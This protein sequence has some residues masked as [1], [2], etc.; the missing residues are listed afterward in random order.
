M[1]EICRDHSANVKRR[2]DEQIALPFV[3]AGMVEAENQFR[4]MNGFL[5]LRAPSPESWRSLR[6]FR[7]NILASLKLVATDHRAV[8]ERQSSVL[9]WSWPLLALASPTSASLLLNS[10]ARWSKRA[11]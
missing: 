7:L 4:R 5:H 2:R 9:A 1:I 3:C 10:V 6:E 11:R 8:E